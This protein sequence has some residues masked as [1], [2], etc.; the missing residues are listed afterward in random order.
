MTLRLS[1]ETHPEP[2]R[3]YG[4]WTASG[5]RAVRRD[6][7]RLSRRYHQI[8]GLPAPALPFLVLCR[9][10]DRRTGAFSLFVGGE[11]EREGLEP[12]DLPAGLYARAEVRPLLGLFWGAAIGGA[13]R[14][15]Y[16]KWLPA[17]GYRPRNLEFEY[18]TARSVGRFPSVDLCFALE[19]PGDGAAP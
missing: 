12:F 11:T 4:L 7:P 2:R 1:L 18:H 14:E 9:D 3:F 6:I 8:S 17:S 15:F 16:A 19:R 10:Y 5:D 13:K